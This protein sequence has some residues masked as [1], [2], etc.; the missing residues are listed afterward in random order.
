MKY[1]IGKRACLSVLFFGVIAV[2]AMLQFPDLH[3]NSDIT[4]VFPQ[5]F[6]S[7]ELVYASDEMA[8]YANSKLLLI[9]SGKKKLEVLSAAEEVASE[10]RHS[11]AVDKVILE[12]DSESLKHLLEVYRK[13][14]IKLMPEEDLNLLHEA[15]ESFYKKQLKRIYRNP[16]ALN[17]DS[18]ANDPFGYTENFFRKVSAHTSTN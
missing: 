1:S 18:F 7:P 5:D 10:F 9:I 12:R 4:A 14:S 17:S 8:R 2:I 15:P 16:S 13:Y 6:Q 11:A 3:L